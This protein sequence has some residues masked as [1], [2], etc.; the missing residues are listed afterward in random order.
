LIADASGNMLEGNDCDD[1]GKFIFL[2][3]GG[4][5]TG[6]N[7]PIGPIRW[8]APEAMLDDTIG[9]TLGTGLVYSPDLGAVVSKEKPKK[10]PHKTYTGHVTV[11]R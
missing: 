9:L 10:K 7:H 2:G 6:S 3:P 11:M 4:L 8:M 1:A 5:P